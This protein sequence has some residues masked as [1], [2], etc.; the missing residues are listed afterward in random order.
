MMFVFYLSGSRLEIDI[1]Q[2]SHQKDMRGIFPGDPLKTFLS[3][4]V[5][6]FLPYISLS[7]YDIWSFWSYLINIRGSSWHTEVGKLVM[8]KDDVI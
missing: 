4:K 8:W 2:N 7:K 6:L 3:E 5:F 1:L